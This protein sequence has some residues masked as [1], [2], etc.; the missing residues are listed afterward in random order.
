LSIHK[1]TRRGQVYALGTAVALLALA[2]C[3][4]SDRGIILELALPATPQQTEQLEVVIDKRQG[5]SAERQSPGVYRIHFE[6][7]GDKYVARLKSKAILR[8]WRRYAI[9]TPEKRYQ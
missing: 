2:G 7:Q 6:R 9:V 3:G 1:T 5:G 8:G 4:C